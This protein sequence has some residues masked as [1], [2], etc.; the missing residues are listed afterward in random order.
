M[1]KSSSRSFVHWRMNQRRLYRWLMNVRLRLWGW[2]V[3]LW[4]QM[5]RKFSTWLCSLTTSCSMRTRSKELYRSWKTSTV[6]LSSSSSCN[7][8]Y[9][10]TQLSIMKLR[11]VCTFWWTISTT[12]LPKTPSAVCLTSFSTSIFC[13]NLVIAKRKGRSTERHRLL[14]KR[15]LSCFRTLRKKSSLLIWLK[16][17]RRKLLRILKKET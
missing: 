14:K 1:W 13:D 9:V 10:I 6:P 7:T 3:V 12:T 15:R 4:S 17:R 8:F 2:T 5:L 11:M 16:I